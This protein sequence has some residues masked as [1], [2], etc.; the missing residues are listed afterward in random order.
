MVHV[1]QSGG[2][3]RHAVGLWLSRFD[4]ALIAQGVDAGKVEGRKLP[5]CLGDQG[6]LN[7]GN[8][9]VAIGNSIPI[10]SLP[11][12]GLSTGPMAV[13]DELPALR[14]DHEERLRSVDIDQL[15]DS[16]QRVRVG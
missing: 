5:F 16:V 14:R 8:T 1:L 7:W 11:R 6:C 9:T 10:G 2:S 3:K 13:R 4:R 12:A 15:R